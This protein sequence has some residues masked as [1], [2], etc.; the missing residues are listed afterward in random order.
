MVMTGKVKWFDDKKGYGFIELD[1][2]SGDVF[3]H[4]TAVEMDGF[5]SLSKGQPVE[6][7]VIEADKGRQATSVKAV[8]TGDESSEIREDLSLDVVQQGSIREPRTEVEPISATE[9]DSSIEGGIEDEEDITD[10]I[11]A[12]DDV[13]TEFD[14]IDDE[15][16]IGD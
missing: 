15:E 13:S 9:K 3:V 16:K 7:D 11:S 10:P 14:K 6:F 2:G 4:Y 8:D 5:K 1:D 12:L